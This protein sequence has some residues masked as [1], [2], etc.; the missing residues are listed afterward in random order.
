MST[1]LG[2]SAA[3]K[4]S[5]VDWFRL[6]SDERFHRSSKREY[7]DHNFIREHCRLGF[8]RFVHNDVDQSLLQLYS[9]AAEKGTI[10]VIGAPF[11]PCHWGTLAVLLHLFRG[12]HDLG[13]KRTVF[14]LTTER[15][16]RALFARLRMH[17][18]FRRVS[19]ALAFC[20]SLEYYDEKAPGTSLV[21][22]RGTHELGSVPQGQSVVVS[23]GHGELVFAR[24]KPRL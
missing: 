23:D 19:E 16:E 6:F 11:T 2:A 14:W 22:L 3:D 10:S 8:D 18:I 4:Q 1:V 15:H 21:F 13:A 12:N 7:S 20:S 17:G 9:K 24:V 5:V